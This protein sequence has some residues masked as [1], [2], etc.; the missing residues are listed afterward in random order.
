MNYL[1]KEL[2]GLFINLGN[3]RIPW[4]DEVKQWSPTFMAS[5]IGFMEDNFCMDQSDDF[6][7]TQEQYIQAHLLLYSL[8]PN[9]PASA[10]G[11]P[12]GQG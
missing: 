5:E 6:R 2:N 4:R 1:F 3:I 11:L 7:M 9:R 10:V 12:Q 8:V